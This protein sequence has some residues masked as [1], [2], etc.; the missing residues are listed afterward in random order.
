MDK[1]IE[2]LKAERGRRYKLA[3]KLRITPGAISQWKKVPAERVGDISRA[4][5]IPMKELRPDIFVKT[6]KAA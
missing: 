3:E 2:W 1:L 6:G 5:G 4:T